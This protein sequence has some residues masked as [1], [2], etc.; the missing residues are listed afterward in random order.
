LR[1]RGRWG[2]SGYSEGRQG[3]Y[4]RKG[5][6]GAGGRG[7]QRDAH[8]KRGHSYEEQMLIRSALTLLQS[9]RRAATKRSRSHGALDRGLEREEETLAVASA[10]LG[11]G[12]GGSRGGG[13]T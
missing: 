9:A 4:K 2:G 6:S 10:S 13:F 8:E 11:E 7:S 12:G 5:G 1:Q 3:Y